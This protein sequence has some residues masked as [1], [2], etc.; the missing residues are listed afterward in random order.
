[1]DCTAIRPLISYYYDGEATPEERT[2]VEQHLAGCEDCRRVIAQYRTIGS[3]IRDLPMPV[4]PV[5]L[6]RDVWRAI[7]TQQAGA[8]RWKQ[9]S[10]QQDKG[11]V[12]DLSTARR[13]KRPALATV[14][15]SMGSGWARALP[16]A[17]LVAALGIMVAV[18]IVIQ[19]RKPT[20][21]AW[22]V[23]PG[24][25]SN[26][27]TAVQ[28]RFS[29]QVI[30]GEVI[31]HTSVGKK[32]GS[33]LSAVET[34]KEFQGQVLTLEPNSPWEA[35]ATYEIRID[36]EKIHVTGIGAPLD[37]KPVTLNFS[38]VLYTPTPTE[39]PLPPT[40]TAIPTD[41][42]EPTMEPTAVAENTPEPTAVVEPTA[43]PQPVEPTVVEPTDTP[44]PAPTNTRKPAPTNTPVP[45]KP[46]A[47]PTEEPTATPTTPAPTPTNTPVSSGPGQK[48]PT[49]TPPAPTPTP[50]RPCDIMPVNG[51]GKIWTENQSV[52]K[53]IGCPEQEEFAILDA[54]H[55]RFEGGY[56]FWRKDIKKIYV[57]FGN[58]NTDTIGTWIEYE[59]TW[60]E[61]EPMPTPLPG[62]TP[63]VRGSTTPPAGKY[64][65]VRGF[66]K[67]WHTNKELRDR[68][69]WALET[70]QGVRGAFQKFEHGYALW[71]DNK[72][73]RFMYIEPGV[74]ENLWERFI[75][76]F[77]TPT[78]SVTPR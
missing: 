40:A 43:T 45:P 53:R 77:A 42:P 73:I 46:S 25:F 10:A 51:F 62:E 18:F 33:S 52:S 36:A 65:P 72:V 15:T 68:L 27:N 7:E 44:R 49:A 9:A 29:K 71:T 41:T 70:E 6:H 16:A 38:V 76:T 69:G 20:E 11:K 48:T 24:P 22:L 13:Q 67:L 8:P 30:P 31:A 61:G 66:G 1:M 4:P 56:M 28:V 78:P 37:N 23:D 75:D 64:A 26:Y 2:Q 60:Q 57:F 34:R 58:P 14:L 54:A 21:L 3:D 74:K 35:G 19:G 47:T 32:E 5:G 39:T 12:V 17:L 50:S 63:G 55:E 59:D